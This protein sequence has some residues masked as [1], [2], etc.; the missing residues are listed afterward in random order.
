[1]FSPDDIKTK[2][3]LRDVDLTH[4]IEQFQWDGRGH[5]GYGGQ[6]MMQSPLC[7]PMFTKLF[8]KEKFQNVIE[9]GTANGGLAMFLQEQAELHNFKFVTY[10][11]KEPSSKS[12]QFKGTNINTIIRDVFDPI[13]IKEIAAI[14]STGKT[15]I[16][17]DGGNKV[18]EF[19]TF[20]PMLNAGD[21]IMA[22]DYGRDK[23]YHDENIKQ[24]W[25]WC[26][27]IDSRISNTLPSVTRYTDIDFEKAGWLCTIKNESRNTKL[28]VNY[29]HLG[30]WALG[31]KTFD[32]LVDTFG[33]KNMTI[34]ELGSGYGTGELSKFFTMYS[35][36]HDFKWLTQPN[37]TTYIH[38]PLIDGWYDIEIVEKGIRGVS[39]DILLIDGPPQGDRINIQKHM[40]LF[41]DTAVWIF[42]DSERPQI[43][44]LASTHK[45]FVNGEAIEIDENGG[46]K[47]TIIIP[48]NKYGNMDEHLGRSINER[49]V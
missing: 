47:S 7:L 38:A 5:F 39:Y 1:M 9:I 6:Y 37:S 29:G 46:K 18:G 15:L 30:G 17:C 19:N 13:S 36:E 26:E 40:N 45:L 27:I 4:I 33:N 8:K 10:D 2:K 34:L 20:T 32:Y 43:A 24:Y 31:K 48:N 44:E 22:H 35:I 41:D 14:I 16:L 12:E 49:T 23:T 3:I 28:D 42:D 11:I 25:K 21:L